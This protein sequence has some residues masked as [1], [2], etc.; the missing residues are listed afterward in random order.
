MADINE[1]MEVEHRQSSCMD[2]IAHAC[3]IDEDVN[4][5]IGLFNEALI[6]GPVQTL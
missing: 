3:Y 1:E 2:N 5:I 4:N 6:C